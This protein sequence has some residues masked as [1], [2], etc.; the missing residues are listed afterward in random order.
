MECLRRSNKT[1]RLRFNY[2]THPFLQQVNDLLWADNSALTSIT[3]T[4]PP[5][6]SSQ[7]WLH[8]YTPDPRTHFL[9]NTSTTMPPLKP[10]MSETEC[11]ISCISHPPL[12]F[13]PVKAPQSL[14]L[15]K[16][17]LLLTP[18]LLIPQH[19]PVSETSLFYL[20]K[21]SQIHSCLSPQL[22]LLLPPTP[23]SNSHLFSLIII[24]AS[25]LGWWFCSPRDIWHWHFWLSMEEVLLA[26]EM[27]LNIMRRI[28]THPPTKNDPDPKLNNAVVKTPPLP[29][30]L[31]QSWWSINVY[32]M[33][34]RMKILSKF[35]F[36]VIKLNQK[37]EGRT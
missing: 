14:Q 21:L 26:P 9:E 13:Y 1:I 36:S 35:Y 18:P 22:P 23:T 30:S 10:S 8:A 12:F 20:L 32:W 7:P 34:E 29:W 24:N 37:F 5:E 17:D 27:L 33:S 11:I 16:P 2:P 19:I 28:V 3:K 31:S 4:L 6:S 15:P 25:Q